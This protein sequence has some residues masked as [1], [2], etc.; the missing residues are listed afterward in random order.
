MDTYTTDLVDAGMQHSFSAPK[1]RTGTTSG[2]TAEASIGKSGSDLVAEHL[3][4]VRFIARKLQAT[5][6]KH[7]ELDDLISAGV[8]GLMDAVGKFDQTKQAQLKSY[9]QFRI[10]GAILD[11][12]RTQDWSPRDLRRKGRQIES[13]VRELT[14]ALG[15][16]PS[17]PEIASELEMTLENFQHLSGEIKGLEIGSLNAERGEDSG[18]AEIASVRCSPEEDPL[19]RCMQGQMRTRLVTAIDNLPE[20]ERLVLTLYYY[21]ELTMREIA[22]TLGVVESRVSQIRS[23]AVARLRT[24]LTA[25]ER[26]RTSVRGTRAN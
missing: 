3:P 22:F 4:M 17:E 16:A 6:P 9:A 21:E 25:P 2:V 24:L 7:I 13:A 1:A 18:E 12:L 14:G 10:R 15:R 20:K 8:L 23:R 11:F 26:T 5:L 19:F